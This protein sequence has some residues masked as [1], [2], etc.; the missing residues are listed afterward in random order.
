MLSRLLTHFS[1]GLSDIV[2]LFSPR[3]CP[4][5]GRMMHE[6]EYFVCTFCRLKAP[7]TNFAADDTNPMAE[8]LRNVIPVRHASALMWFVADSDWQRAVHNMKYRFR[9]RYAAMLGEWLG[10]ELRLSGMYDDVDAVTYVPLHPLKRIGRGYDQAELIAEGVASQMHLPVVR[11]AVVR[12]VNNPSQTQNGYLERLRNVDGIFAVRHPGRLE[13]RHLL[14]VD[15]VF[16]TGATILSCGETI[17]RS[18]NNVELSIAT[19]ALSQ[20]GFAIDR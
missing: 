7:L 15:D 12:C 16:T 4:V 10:G 14:L 2:N 19:I 17:I 18:A 9:P 5:C 6:G 8:Y 1:T 20:T 3:T 11:G 13:G